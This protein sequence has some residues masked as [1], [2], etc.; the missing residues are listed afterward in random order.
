MITN[1]DVLNRAITDAH[2][3]FPSYSPDERAA[4]TRRAETALRAE[5]DQTP[6]NAAPG[7]PGG[8]GVYARS[9]CGGPVTREYRWSGAWLCEQ[10]HA[11]V[12]AQEA[13]LDI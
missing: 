10:H 4:A 12:A 6:C 5:Q 8:P 7:Q 3:D 1:Q 2:G 13:F 11:D 9:S